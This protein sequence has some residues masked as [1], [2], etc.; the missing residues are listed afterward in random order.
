MANEGEGHP[1]G[2]QGA[3]NKACWESVWYLMKVKVT[4]QA[5]KEL[6]IRHAGSLSGS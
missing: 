3:A 4:P 1:S 2:S 5:A 6:P